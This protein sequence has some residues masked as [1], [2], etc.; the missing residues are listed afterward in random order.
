MLVRPPPPPLFR[1]RDCYIT[2]SSEEHCTGNTAELRALTVKNREDELRHRNTVDMNGYVTVRLQGCR[3]VH[4]YSPS[5]WK[6]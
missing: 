3:N 4:S 1:D 5:L 2:L 6:G